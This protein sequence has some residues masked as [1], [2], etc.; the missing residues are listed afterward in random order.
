MEN[1]T[2]RTKS[3]YDLRDALPL[4]GCPVCRLRA[5]ATDHML[6]GIIYENVNDPGLRSRIVEARGFCNEHAWALQRSGAALG[7]S[8]MLRDVIRELLRTLNSARFNS[9]AALSL[10][11]V[12]EAWDSNRPRAATAEVVSELG[13]QTICPICIRV[14]DIETASLDSLLENLFSEDEGTLLLAL[15]VSDGLCLPHLR[16]ALARVPNEDVFR[17]LVRAQES[18]WSRLESDLCEIIRKSDYR[19]SDEPVGEEG[20][21]WLRALETTAGARRTFGR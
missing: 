5:S 21:A 20:D 17:Q 13:P 3:Y 7:V 12:Q 11:R 6:D 1:K 16:Q 15:Q 9:P 18:I 8:L 10:G 19:F 4:P 14:R 2:G